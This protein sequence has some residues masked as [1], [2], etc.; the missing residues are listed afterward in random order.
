[1]FDILLSCS[2]A[3]ASPRDSGGYPRNSVDSGTVG[4]QMT[5]AEAEAWENAAVVW[6]RQKNIQDNNYPT[7]QDFE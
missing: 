5:E 1:M 2:L 6:P 7:C 4:S 3:R